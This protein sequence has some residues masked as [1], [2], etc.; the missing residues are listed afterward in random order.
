MLVFFGK[1]DCGIV[2]I[3]CLFWTAIP[4][5]YVLFSYHCSFSPYYPPHF[6]FFFS[7]CFSIPPKNSAFDWVNK[8]IIQLEPTC[9]AY[10]QFGFKLWLCKTNLSRITKAVR[11]IPS[12]HYCQK[13]VSG[14]GEI[15]ELQS[16]WSL[17][18]VYLAQQMD[19]PFV[20]WAKP[21]WTA[22][23]LLLL[24]TCFPFSIIFFLFL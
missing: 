17:V 5:H 22:P 20:E 3:Q 12:W 4:H 1:Q 21:V 18:V 24:T 11:T 7:P 2:M 8:K 9:Q 23:H 14:W 19:R 16:N 13:R 10:P 6:S 15:S